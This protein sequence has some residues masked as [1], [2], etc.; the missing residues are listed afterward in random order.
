MT[1]SADT[2]AEVA[3]SFPKGSRGARAI[4]RKTLDLRTDELRLDVMCLELARLVE[5]EIA[6]HQRRA[7]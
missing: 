4:A 1:I 5:A 2:L 3:H 6:E 7:R